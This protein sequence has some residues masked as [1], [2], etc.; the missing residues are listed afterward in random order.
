MTNYI[1]HSPAL[2]WMLQNG[3]KEEVT[4]VVLVGEDTYGRRG[5]LVNY[6]A[7]SAIKN[8]EAFATTVHL[9]ETCGFAASTHFRKK[10]SLYP[11]SRGGSR[12]RRPT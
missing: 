6:L 2:P 7:W 1:C 10:S 4:F 9:F 3:G 12:P 11:R 5:A 8:R